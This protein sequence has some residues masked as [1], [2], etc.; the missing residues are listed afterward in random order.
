MHAVWYPV[1]ALQW[2]QFENSSQDSGMRIHAVWEPATA[3]GQLPC[4]SASM[5]A[6]RRQ[7]FPAGRLVVWTMQACNGRQAVMSALKPNNG[8]NFES[9]PSNCYRCGF[10]LPG[11]A[12]SSGLRGR[13]K[14]TIPSATSE[15]DVR[16]TAVTIWWSGL[17]I[18]S[19][20]G[21]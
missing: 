3:A 9:R 13:R 2:L 12:S 16:S 14:T 18:S 7:K 6:A 10:C 1:T 20:V 19:V 15:A 4:S 21:L 11:A 17:A 8:A 5:H